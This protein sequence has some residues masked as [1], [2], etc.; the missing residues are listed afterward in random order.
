MSSWYTHCTVGL[1]S[2]VTN[3][4]SGCT[5]PDIALFRKAMVELLN[6]QPAA[7]DVSTRS[8]R[9]PEVGC[10]FPASKPGKLT[11]VS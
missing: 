3:V 9:N 2:L 8:N 5:W 7:D 6:R 11:C 4:S 1:R 10:C